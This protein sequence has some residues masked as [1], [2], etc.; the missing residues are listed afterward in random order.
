MAALI[1]LSGIFSY[2]VGLTHGRYE[3][4]AAAH[5]IQ[6]AMAAGPD[7]ATDWALLMANNDPGP[8]LA[9]CKKNIATDEYGRRS[10]SMPMWLDPP[11]T[12]HP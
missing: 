2:A 3:G 9:E 4:E 10:C 5:A 12:G 7:A 11:Q 1:V 8:E 6:S